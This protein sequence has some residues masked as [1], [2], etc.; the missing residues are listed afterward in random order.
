MTVV[1]AVLLK[2]LTNSTRVCAQQRHGHSSDLNL[3]WVCLLLSTADVLQPLH[4]YSTYMITL[5]ILL[6]CMYVGWLGFIC[7]L[8]VLAKPSKCLI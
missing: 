6:W 5:S 8:P 4:S 3:G 7:S 2:Y 1:A